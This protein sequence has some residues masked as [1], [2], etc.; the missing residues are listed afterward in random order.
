MMKTAF[1]FDLINAY[2]QWGEL[3]EVLFDD[4]AVGAYDVLVYMR[5]PQDEQVGKAS[6]WATMWGVQGNLAFGPEAIT[7]PGPW[8]TRT[9]EEGRQYV[10]FDNVQVGPKNGPGPGTD[11]GLLYLKVAAQT[12]VYGLGP[13]PEQR[14]I[15][16]RHTAFLNGVQLLRRKQVPQVLFN[17]WGLPGSAAMWGQQPIQLWSPGI[18]SDAAIYIT[19]TEDET[20]PPEP[21]TGSHLYTRPLWPERDGLP[22][23]MAVTKV[24]IKAK[25]FKGGYAESLTSYA[26]FVRAMP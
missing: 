24:K 18:G 9:W 13:P 25:A 7:Q 26:E 3:I 17:P 22:E 23:R 8:K 2:S 15:S 11:V 20:E 21:T 1:G 10:R 12:V 16:F 19:W 5:G 14:P 4:L 6:G